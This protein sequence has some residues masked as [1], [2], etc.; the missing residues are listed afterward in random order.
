MEGHAK[1]TGE[2]HLVMPDIWGYLF[3]HVAAVCVRD[4]ACIFGRER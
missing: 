2:R 3:L 4:L 1:G